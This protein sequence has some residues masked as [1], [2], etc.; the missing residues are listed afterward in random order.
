MGK[1][2]NKLGGAE[3]PKYFLACLIVFMLVCCFI[4][5]TCNKTTVRK[6][7]TES[8]GS[9]KG[10]RMYYGNTPIRITS[11]GGLP[12]IRRTGSGLDVPNSKTAM[13]ALYDEQPYNCKS[14]ERGG[15]LDDKQVNMHMAKQDIGNSGSNSSKIPRSITDSRYLTIGSG[16]Y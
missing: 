6:Y 16:Q 2:K 15:D 1:N 9:D 5:N 4:Y 7:R 13:R 10:S 11:N 3:L 8:I 14:L 12:Y